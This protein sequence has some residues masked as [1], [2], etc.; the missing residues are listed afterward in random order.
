M[1]TTDEEVYKKYGIDPTPKKGFDKEKLEKTMEDIAYCRANLEKVNETRDALFEVLDQLP[2]MHQHMVKMSEQ[3]YVLA[4]HIKRLED[5]TGLT[6][7]DN[8]G[9]G[10]DTSGGN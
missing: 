6:E 10:V 5:V 3:I 8:Q 1:A 4:R 9:D 7:Y 2:L